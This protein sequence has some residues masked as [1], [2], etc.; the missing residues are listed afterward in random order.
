VAIWH[1]HSLKNAVRRKSVEKHIMQSCYFLNFRHKNEKTTNKRKVF[2]K[3]FHIFSAFRSVSRY[4]SL[5]L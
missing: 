5:D 2:V 4:V 3:Y 1:N